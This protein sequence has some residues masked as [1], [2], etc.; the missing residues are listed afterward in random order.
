MPHGQFGMNFSSPSHADVE[1]TPQD[2]V[3][4]VEP[5]ALLPTMH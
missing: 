5:V 1:L 2:S 4:R 3:A